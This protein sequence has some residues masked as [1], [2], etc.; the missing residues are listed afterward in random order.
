MDWES[1]GWHVNG[2][3]DSTNHQRPCRRNTLKDVGCG[4]VKEFHAKNNMLPY[5]PPKCA[6]VNANA[7]GIALQLCN[8]C[9]DPNPRNRPMFADITDALES[10]TSKLLSNDAAVSCSLN[11]TPV[12]THTHTH[13]TFTFAS[14]PFLRFP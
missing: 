12:P 7:F 9:R 13:I 2:R 14:P 5:I 11:S 1:G 3:L 10:A 6:R 8:L 4:S